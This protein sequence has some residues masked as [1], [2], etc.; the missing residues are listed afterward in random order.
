MNGVKN[1]EYKEEDYY[2]EKEKEWIFKSL[3]STHQDEFLKANF[4]FLCLKK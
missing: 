1:H 4:Y 2:L 3:K